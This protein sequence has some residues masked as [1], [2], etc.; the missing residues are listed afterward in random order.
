MCPVSLLLIIA[1]RTKKKKVVQRHNREVVGA[2]GRGL[3]GS[4]RL[5]EK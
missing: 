4:L 2:E 1:Q 3:P 5:L